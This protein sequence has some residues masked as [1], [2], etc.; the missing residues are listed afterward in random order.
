MSTMKQQFWKGKKVLVT[1]HTG[2]K[3]SWLTIWLK[4]LGAEVSGYALKP[5]TTQDNFVV[6]GLDRKINHRIGDVRNYEQLLQCF[7]E[8]PPEIVFHLA[9]QPLVRESYSNPKSTYD[10]NVGG[11]VNVLEC[12]RQV[13]SVRVI[14]NVTTDKCY[15]NKEWVWGYRENDRLGGYDPYSSSKA[16]SELVTEAYRKS[17][18]NPGSFST[19]GKSLASARAGNVF[20]GGDWQADRI[21]PDSIRHL[22]R[23]EPIIVRSPHA[24][25]PWQHVLEPLSGYLLLAEKMAGNPSAH[26]EGWNFGPEDSSFLSVGALVD[27]IVK[28]WGEGSWQGHSNP[29]ALHEAN[30]LKLDINKAKSLLGWSPQ[31]NIEKAVAETVSW[32]KQYRSGDMYNLCCQQITDYMKG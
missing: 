25:R 5:L 17:F 23:G 12:C 21:V 27:N 6:A 19:H 16:C 24:I 11:T 20:G 32:Y 4:M 22:E 13:E 18:F 15:D 26:A 7:Y 29:A 31:W 14:V 2:F 9:A 1:G 10:I 30:L 3:G 8:A 28:I